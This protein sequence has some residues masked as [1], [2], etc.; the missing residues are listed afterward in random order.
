GTYTTHP[1]VRNHYLARLTGSGQAAQ[2]HAQLQAY[3]LALAGDTPQHPTLEQLAPLI[4]VVYHA[5]RAG[6]Y[7]EAYNILQDRIYQGWPDRVL[8]NQLGAWETAVTL[9][10]QFF[11][12]G[13][14]SQEPQMSKASDKSWILNEVGLCHMSL[15]RLE[16]A[17][18]FY[19][20]VV[21]MDKTIQ[22]WHQASLTLQNL[23]ELNANLGRLA[24]SAAA[25]A[26][27]LE[28]ARR[29]ANKQDEMKSL[30]WQAWA[31]HLRGEA[32]GEAFRQAEALEREIDSSKQYLYSLRG[33]HHVEYLRRVGEAAY[34]RRVTAANLEI[35]ESNRFTVR[36]SLCHSLMGTLEAD[37]GDQDAARSQFENALT[38]ARGISDRAVLIEALLVR[39][40]WAA[41]LSAQDPSGLLPQAFSDLHEALGYATDS[42]YRIY[43]ADIR[44]ALAWAHLA[45]AKSPALLE[46]PGTS[47]S[48][49]LSARQEAAR[50]QSLSQ[51]I[52]YHW[53]L[54][55]AAAV[56]AEIPNP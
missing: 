28:L 24:A 34:A 2:T 15:G 56:L 16:T 19:E 30:K 37:A 6:A 13:D 38:I 44:I 9:M 3:Y 7:D 14:T 45:A 48:S 21:E 52:G 26:Q 22:D 10:Q 18:S 46:V 20:R 23:A 50:A 33:I 25:A 11:P 31:A 47:G 8:A 54:V 32:A 43:E 36:L 27:A 49:Y 17:V 42:G 53:G 5:C 29:A 1:L 40:R 55:D 39:G 51:E 4:E 12:D 35:C 41:Q